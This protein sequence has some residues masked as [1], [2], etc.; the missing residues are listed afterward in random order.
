[1]TLSLSLCTGCNLLSASASEE[2]HSKL[3]F[4]PNCLVDEVS[5]TLWTA[6]WK[7]AEALWEVAW[8]LWDVVHAL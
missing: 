3:L 6:L 7:N 8:A 1:M 5:E 4:Y 2:L